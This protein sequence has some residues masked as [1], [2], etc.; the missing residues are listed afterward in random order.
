MAKHRKELEE[1]KESKFGNSVLDPAVDRELKDRDQFGDPLKLMQSKTIKY[2]KSDLMYRVLTT[3]SEQKYI[4]QRCKF[5]STQNR[6]NIQAGSKWDGVDRSNDYERK[7]MAREAD[8]DANKSAF[9][10]WA[11]QEM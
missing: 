11:S 4:L 9:H 5:P 7:W 2:G 6:F 10:K 1:A 3:Q 8:L